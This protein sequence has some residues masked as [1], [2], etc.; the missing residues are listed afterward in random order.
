MSL[1]ARVIVYLRVSRAEQTAENQFP[2][3]EKWITALGHELVIG[4][5]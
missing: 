2:P 5:I 4:F 1:M 3:L